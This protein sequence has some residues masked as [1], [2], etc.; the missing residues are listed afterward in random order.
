MM[1]FT[2]VSNFPPISD[3]FFG[4]PNFPNFTFSK[5]FS[6]FSL[7]KISDDVFFFSHS[8]KISNSP[9]FPVSVHFPPI[10]ENFHSSPTFAN[11]HPDFV[12]FTCFYILYVCFVC[13]LLLQ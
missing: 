8:P 7:A 11:F 12:K 10:S 2:S 4:L 1:H 9:Y 13:P 6:R 3:K 5:N